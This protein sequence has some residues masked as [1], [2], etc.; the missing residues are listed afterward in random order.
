MDEEAADAKQALDRRNEIVTSSIRDMAQELGLAQ[1]EVKEAFET[2]DLAAA[3]Q[4]QVEQVEPWKELYNKVVDGF[5]QDARAQHEELKDL[6]AD[7]EASTRVFGPRGDMAAIGSTNRFRRAVEPIDAE[8]RR[9][10]EDRT[11]IAVT[12]PEGSQGYE[13]ALNTDKS[14]EEIRAILEEAEALKVLFRDLEI[15][16]DNMD[17]SKAR[18]ALEEATALARQLEQLEKLEASR[19]QQAALLDKLR[20]S[21]EA[22]ELE[23]QTQQILRQNDAITR[24]Q[25]ETEARKLLSIRAQTD[26]L[27]EQYQVNARIQD[28]KDNLNRDEKELRVLWEALA[29]SKE[30]YQITKEMLRLRAEY[31]LQLDDETRALAERNLRLQE[32]LETAESIAEA[33]DQVPGGSPGRRGRLELQQDAFGN[34]RERTRE[35]GD[36]LKDVWAD[37]FTSFVDEG[38]DAFDIITDY[39]RDRARQNFRDVLDTLLTPD[40]NSPFG[41]ATPGINGPSP[42]SAISLRDLFFGQD[43]RG[44]IV[45]QDGTQVTGDPFATP[46]PRRG[47][48]TQQVAQGAAVGLNIYQGYQ[49]N[50]TA[51][52]LNSAAQT[53]AASSPQGAL[54]ILGGQIGLAVANEIDGNGAN[55]T[56]AAFGQFFGAIGG[57]IAGLTS[58]RSNFTGVSITDLRQGRVI[59]ADQRDNSE[60]S[61]ANRQLSERIGTTVA[62]TLGSVLNITGGSLR[63]NRNTSYR[64]DLLNVDVGSRDGIQIG[65]QG[66]DGRPKAGRTFESSEAGA[67]DAIEYAFQLAFDQVEGGTQSLVEFAKAALDAGQGVE[68]MVEGLQNIQTA[69][70]YNKEPVSDLVTRL[71]DINEAF[72]LADAASKSAGGIDS[73]NL[74]AERNQALGRVATDFDDQIRADRLAIDSSIQGQA[75]ALFDSQI[76]RLSDAKALSDEVG[77][78]FK[79]ALEVIALNRSELTQFIEQAATSPEAFLDLTEALSAVSDQAAKAGVDLATV[80]A[81]LKLAGEDAAAAFD[82]RVR[83]DRLAVDS[84]LQAQAEALLEGQIARLRDANA[85]S[86]QVGGGDQ[87]TADVIGLNTAEL[88]EFINQ[89]AEGPDTFLQLSDALNAVSERAAEAGV[90]LGA[91]STALEAARKEAASSFDDAQ[92]SRLVQSTNDVA[93]RYNEIIKAQKDLVEQARSLGANVDLVQRANAAERQAFLDGLSDEDRIELGDALG[94]LEDNLGRTAYLLSSLNQAF[95]DQVLSADETAAEA[96]QLADQWRSIHDSLDQGIEQIFDRYRPGTLA[97]QSEQLRGEFFAADARARDGSLSIEDRQQAAAEALRAGESLLGVERQLGFTSTYFDTIFNQVTERLGSLQ[98]L[99][100]E[101]GNSQ[102]TRADSAEATATALNDLYQA[103]NQP[104]VE[105]PELINIQTQLAE[106][107]QHLSGQADAV[108]SLLDEYIRSRQSSDGL[109]AQADQI[110]SVLDG[111]ITADQLGVG[112]TTL[113]TAANDNGGANVVGFAGANQTAVVAATI[114]QVLSLKQTLAGQGRTANETASQALSV[115]RDILEVLSAMRSEESQRQIDVI[116]SFVDAA[117]QFQ[118][119]GQ[120][121]GQPSF[122]DQRANQQLVQAVEQMRDALATAVNEASASNA[123]ANEDVI[124]GLNN[125]VSTLERAVDEAHD[126]LKRIE[127]H[128]KTGS[129]LTTGAATGTGG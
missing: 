76:D 41:A 5:I 89:A 109:A 95:S 62:Q 100:N 90:D 86:A 32:G 71:N 26:A 44:P 29:I 57:L 56:T 4:K 43:N 128:L 15:S 87:R 74:D 58:K 36:Q 106:A 53:L 49:Q 93:F 68:G 70:D 120:P 125:R 66:Q 124:K 79:R 99:V 38:I 3:L 24:E 16:L 60:E 2:F 81:A 82:E 37:V 11:R 14:V 88:A 48:S 97:E 67:R 8:A 23:Q 54:A 119:A 112:A 51:G 77:G 123:A 98:D 129:A 30:E 91:V 108:L 50:G 78:S 19:G 117:P 47:L 111:Q 84:P 12:F 102:Q 105:V 31:G 13:L 118:Q 73:L 126:T 103:L 121:A 9:L 110:L 63:D 46:A 55:E 72:D 6:M 116:Q 35:F 85:L 64:E 28:L 21:K 34:L 39:F 101:E 22:Y 42:V 127:T 94:L 40:A 20:I 96:Q 65:F 104:S 17:A 1:S 45:G 52:A 27:N 113:A 69:L 10:A 59:N 122:D 114:G 107:N 115:D 92:E 83:T 80:S 61:T 18:K 25:A 7:V 33:Y 75:E